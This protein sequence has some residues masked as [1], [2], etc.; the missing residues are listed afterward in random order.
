MFCEPYQSC[1]LFGALR[2]VANMDKVVSVIHGPTGCSFYA[3]NSIIR[4][5]G[6][7]S[8]SERIRVPIIYSTDFNENDTIFGGVQKLKC[9]VS[10]IVEHDCPEVM[11]IF[12]SCVSE[13]IGE[14]INS[15]AEEM[16]EKYNI[17]VIPVHTAGF[18]GDHKVGMKMGNEIVFKYFMKPFPAPKD[19]NR[20]NILGDYDYFNRS[21]SELNRIIELM[22]G[23]KVV[24]IPGTS[25]VGELRKATG[26]ALNVIT[27]K[28]A[29]QHLAIMMR[30]SFGI[31]YIGADASMYGIDNCYNLYSQ[32][33]SFFGEDIKSLT[34]QYVSAK[35]QLLPYIVQMKG[36]RAVVI[37]GTRRALGYSSLLTEMGLNVEFIFTESSDVSTR[38]DLLKYSHNIMCDEYPVKLFRKIDEMSPD[39]VFSTLPE[40]VAPNK[41]VSRN[42][43]DYTGFCGALNL[44]R[45]LV[46][47]RKDPETTAYI[48]MEN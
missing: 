27:C 44:A 6:Y 34:D 33:F 18:K 24:H 17:P 7:Y 14:D 4:L 8:A 22:P 47:V 42:D 20:I 25:S 10:E 12:N 35:D 46:S 1:S 5:N 13:I 31:P 16:S 3:R 2:I 30:E 15:V 9:A 28:N 23:K 11:F 41:Y 40:I 48:R 21:S 37:A 45:Y 39:Y 43:E 19:P 26:A 32:I 38:S 29:S 36:K